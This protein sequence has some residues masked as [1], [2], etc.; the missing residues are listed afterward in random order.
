MVKR[1]EVSERKF[2]A[3]NVQKLLLDVSQNH[4]KTIE[5]FPIHV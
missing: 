4:L 1:R 2:G 3:E 5:L